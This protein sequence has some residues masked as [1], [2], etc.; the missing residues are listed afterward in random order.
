MLVH[1]S[2]A[3]PPLA[4]PGCLTQNAHSATTWE[5]RRICN[6]LAAKRVPEKNIM[7]RSQKFFCT[8]VLACAQFLGLQAFAGEVLVEPATSRVPTAEQQSAQ[9]QSDKER[10]MQ[11]VRAELED[12]EHRW[13]GLIR[14]RY[15]SSQLLSVG[16]GVIFVEQP[17][18]E[19][20]AIG[21]MLHGWQFAVEPGV[22]G[23]QGSVG[24]G[25]LA[26]ETGQLKHLIPTVYFGWAVR[27]AVLRTWGNSR[28]IAPDQTFAG[29]EANFSILRINF[30]AGIMH[31]LASNSPDQWLYSGSVG[32]GF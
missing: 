24:W 29:V 6:P 14:A 20:C 28:P 17:K 1:R 19:K 21:C 10:A 31:S 18:T 11:Q 3:F 30:A 32:W 12:T 16:L 15:S 4:N 2:L 5:K 8:C 25:R 22:Y 13:Y 27:A 23:L 26:G 9:A 7:K